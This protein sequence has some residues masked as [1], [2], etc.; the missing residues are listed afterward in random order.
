M[1]KLVSSAKTALAKKSASK[2]ASPLA[3]KKREA[4]VQ[5]PR[6]ERIPSSF[7]LV[8]NGIAAQ[9]RDISASGIFFEIDENAT[10]GSIINFSLQLDTPGGTL[11]LVGEGEVV[12]QER[13]DGKLGVA[14]KIISQSL[15]HNPIES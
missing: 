15:D 8:A 6:H 12:R 11:N 1:K 3:R 2:V 14:I 10:L 7:P 9:T 4:N 5:R 13:H